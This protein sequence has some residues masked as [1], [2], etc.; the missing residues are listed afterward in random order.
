MVATA[1]PSDD[2]LW[3]QRLARSSVAIACHGCCWLAL[4]AT[5]WSAS[6]AWL[7]TMR[8]LDIAPGPLFELV[9]AFAQLVIDHPVITVACTILLL[10][11][12]FALLSLLDRTGWRGFARECWTA[13]FVLP[14][15]LGVLLSA[16]S[17]LV[18]HA[19][20]TMESYSEAQDLNDLL[21]RD[22]GEDWL[23]RMGQLEGE[24]KLVSVEQQGRLA[25]DAEVPSSKLRIWKFESMRNSLGLADDSG[26]RRVVYQYRWTLGSQKRRGHVSVVRSAAAEL[27][28]IAFVDFSGDTE[29]IRQVGV[30]RRTDG[31]LEFCVAPPGI[32]GDDVPT[33]F[34]T[35][36]HDR[37][38]LYVF[39]RVKQT[40][41]MT[42]SSEES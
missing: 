22:D 14:A 37:N 34:S 17:L 38:V 11:L 40:I 33:T 24:W 35:T 8:D 25:V 9:G 2:Q 19:T 29:H 6:A 42:A 12:D 1:N 31:R 20:N 3:K 26:H 5:Q 27:E 4:L 32:G 7:N 30:C 23:E 10:V 21:N 36:E 41:D 15:V 13:I 28:R 16:M 39:E 18:D